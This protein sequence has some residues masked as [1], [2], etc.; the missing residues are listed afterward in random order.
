MQ[1]CS[2]ENEMRMLEMRGGG[3]IGLDEGR[4]GKGISDIGVQRE[5]EVS[6]G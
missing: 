6:A 3:S 1:K 2:H 5:F 4:L